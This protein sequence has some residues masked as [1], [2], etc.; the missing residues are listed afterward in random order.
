MGS[1]QQ[2]TMAYVQEA[3]NQLLTTT[4][5]E[6]PEFLSATQEGLDSSVEVIASMGLTGSLDASLAVGVSRKGANLLVSKMLGSDPGEF[7][8]DTVDGVGELV[9]MFA[10]IIKTKFED[11]GCVFILSLPVVVTGTVPMSIQRLVK[12]EG[13]VLSAR[14]FGII[15]DIFFFYSRPSMG[16]ARLSDVI[17]KGLSSKDATEALMK[18]LAQKPKI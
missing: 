3:M 10:G 16:L 5:K 18:M 1:R 9:N 13:V 6:A 4:F 11:S 17:S 15:L 8:Q 2:A 12:S 14:I 7:N